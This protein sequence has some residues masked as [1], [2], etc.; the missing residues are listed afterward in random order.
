M[1]VKIKRQD[2]PDT[3]PYWQI[4][5]YDIEGR[6]T[7]AGILD[8]LNY[9]DDLFDENGVACKRIKWECSCMQKVCGACAIV[10]NH[11]PALACSTFIDTKKT[12]MLV[13][14]P[15][16]KFPVI[17]DLIVDRSCIMEYMKQT[18][19]YIGVHDI[20]QTKEFHNQ[21][22][23]AKCLKCGLCLEI[24][25]NYTG[26]NANFFGAVFANESFL[27]YTLSQ[28]RKKELKKSYEKHFMN[29]CSKSLACRDICP[30]KIPTLSSIGYMNRR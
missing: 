27:T 25:P 22:S 11:E 14:E 29:G 10:I 6:D 7:V 15:L 13:L 17:A 28:D 20:T 9:R 18:D 8:Y 16:S 2:G 3:K 30:A 1:R 24:C 5:K 12:K 26:E 23:V 21:Y 4:F 19:E